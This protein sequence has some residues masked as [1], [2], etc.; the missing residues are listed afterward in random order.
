MKIRLDLFSSLELDL[1]LV[2]TERDLQTGKAR[3]S[4]HH[5][6]TDA[7]FIRLK[8]TMCHLH[9]NGTQPIAILLHSTHAS[10]LADGKQRNPDFGFDLYS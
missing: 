6:D 10:I 4:S 9:S 7:F 3:T 2:Q 5:V 8:N 1:L